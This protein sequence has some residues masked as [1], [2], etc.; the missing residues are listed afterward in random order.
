MGLTLSNKPERFQI[1][2][3]NAG[4]N[5]VFNR[6]DA[7]SADVERM[8][9]LEEETKLCRHVAVSLHWELQTAD[10]KLQ[11]VQCLIFSK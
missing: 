9:E 7:N 8:N 3:S 10:E 6:N 1:V 2:R 11:K 4:F 5:E